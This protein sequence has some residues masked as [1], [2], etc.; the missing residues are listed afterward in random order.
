MVLAVD[1]SALPYNIILSIACIIYYFLV[2]RNKPISETGK[3]IEK[4]ALQ[5]TIPTPEEKKRLD[6]QYTFWK[7]G[8][9]GVFILSCGLFVIGIGF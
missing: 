2:V 9:L 3:E 7:I 6:K 1:W 5:L 8:A 4:E